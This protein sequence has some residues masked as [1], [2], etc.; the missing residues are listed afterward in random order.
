MTPFELIVQD[1]NQVRDSQVIMQEPPYDNTMDEKRKIQITYNCLLRAQRN[2]QRISALIFAYFLGQLI[3]NR[4]LSKREIKQLITEH[5]YSIAI[6]T[7]YIFEI[8]PTIIYSTSIISV[9][10]IIKLK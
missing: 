10:L 5:F 1:L 8:D 2:K 7:F 9:N 3:K 6:R 4:L